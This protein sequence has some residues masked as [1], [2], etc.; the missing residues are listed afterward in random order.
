M[1]NY[2]EIKPAKTV[3]WVGLTIANVYRS[4]LRVND[5][6]AGRVF[7]AILTYAA[8]PD[9]KDPGLDS[10]SIESV[11]FGLFVEEL[12]KSIEVYQKKVQGGQIGGLQAQQNRR[13]AKES[14]ESG[15]SGEGNHKGDLDTPKPLLNDSST[16]DIDK[17][18]HTT[19]EVPNT[20]KGPLGYGYTVEQIEDICQKNGIHVNAA[21]VVKVNGP[22]GWLLEGEPI[23]DI[24]AYLRSW[25]KYEM[26]KPGSKSPAVNHKAYND[27]LDDVFNQ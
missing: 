5:A 22:R 6:V 2:N 9:R 26:N 1:E 27:G 20:D 14:A 16:Q 8:D 24:V 13:I 4:V 17:D 25:E 15:E 3:P 10:D 12:D 11:L 18:R 23:R 7:K 19:F 21:R